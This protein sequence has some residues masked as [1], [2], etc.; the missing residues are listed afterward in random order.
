MQNHG[1]RETT[2][3]LVIGL[4][5]I[6]R[7]D[8]GVGVHLARALARESWPAGVRILDA[9]TPGLALLDLIQEA[10][11][12]LIL[13]AGDFAE[14]PASICVFT[15]DEV[16][17]RSESSPLSIHQ[18]DVLGALRLGQALG[19]APPMTLVAIQPRSLEPGTELSPTLTEAFPKLLAC[20]HTLIRSL[21]PPP[22]AGDSCSPPQADSGLSA[23]EDGQG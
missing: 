9:G 7:S 5:N 6:L 10:D 4:G 23:P 3:L 14:P 11:H 21:A 12:V 20:V 1:K 22:A 15:P 13:D 19:I 8:D 18:A 17:S 16:S 2:R